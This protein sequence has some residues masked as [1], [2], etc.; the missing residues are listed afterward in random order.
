MRAIS[1][2]ALSAALLLT[3]CGRSPTPV[4]PGAAGPA[5]FEKYCNAPGAPRALRQTLLIIDE[6]EVQPNAAPGQLAAGNRKWTLWIGGLLGKPGD[7][8]SSAFS[9]RERL[10]VLLAPRNGAEPRTVFTGCVPG[11]SADE[12]QAI[13]KG[14]GGI[15][16]ASSDFFGSG[17]VQTAAKDA[18]RFRSLLGSA[19][20]RLG[21]SEN[22]TKSAEGGDALE[23]SS[24]LTSLR[25]KSLVDL[26]AG[27]PRIVIFSDMSRL[28]I[29]GANIPEARSA[30]F[31]L[32]RRAPLDLKRAEV[33][34]AGVAPDSRTAQVRAFV[35]AFLLGSEGQLRGFGSGDIGL[36]QI[37]PQ[38]VRVY[39]GMIR[40][41]SEDVPMRLRLATTNDGRIIDS[42]IAVRRDVETATPFE[43]EIVSDGRDGEIGRNDSKGLGQLWSTDPD[44][45]PEFG[46]DLAFGGLRGLELRVHPDGALDG[47]VMDPIVNKING[48]AKAY[49]EFK[50][51]LDEKSQF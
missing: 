13:A 35:D 31:A 4:N 34:V 29:E 50:L 47:R 36:Q 23:T 21:D 10:T 11:F 1:L 40:Y 51:H 44:P 5:S 18:D 27:I 32:A 17:P 16:S 20:A 25:Q 28:S 15:G 48:S 2:S 43:G 12:V 9:P 30:G 14:Q 24:L 3:A 19:L 49:I 38:S 37:A 7:S 22:Q 8:K 45:E 26:S 6:N 39:S 41:G 33:F 46:S 42:W